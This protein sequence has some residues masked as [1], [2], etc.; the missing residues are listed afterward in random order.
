MKKGIF[1]L[2]VVASSM[3]LSV[4]ANASNYGYTVYK[5]T[6]SGAQSITGNTPEG[7]DTNLTGTVYLFIDKKA[8][9]VGIFM[10]ANDAST[11]TRLHLH[12]GVAGQNG[13]LAIG[14]I[15]PGPL[16]INGNIVRGVLDNS[17]IVGTGC[18]DAIGRPLNNIASLAAAMDAGAIYFNVHT[19][20]F[21]GG[22]ARAQMSRR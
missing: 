5:G 1:L 6:F 20:T 9:E 3:M 19:S 14:F 7:I 18:E 22:E 13:P 2:F 8:S 10:R 4:S 15:E 12:C 21:P 16:S 11:I 17:N